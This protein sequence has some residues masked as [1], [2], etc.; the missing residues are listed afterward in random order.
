MNR[1]V[2]D[3][4]ALLA[5]LRA[6]PGGEEVAESI[7]GAAISAV[8]LSEVVSKLMERGV[9]EQAVRSALRGVELEIYP[10]EEDLAY[11][12]GVL[13]MATREA[14][15]SLGDR[16]C[17]ALAQQLAAPALTTDRN[18]RTLEVGIEIRIIR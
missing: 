3:A 1:V 18:W 2:L 13:R 8:N 10:F 15:L 9:P 7:P 16:A 6:E 12:T 17:L 5:L 14:G 4:S 11:R